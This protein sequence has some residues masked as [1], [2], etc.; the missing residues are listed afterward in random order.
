VRAGRWGGG[1]TFIEAGVGECER[2]FAEKKVGKEIVAF[3]I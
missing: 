3:E 1:S 2:G